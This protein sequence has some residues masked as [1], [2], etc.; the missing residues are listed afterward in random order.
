MDKIHI[1]M[2]V[3]PK[4]VFDKVFVTLSHYDQSLQMTLTSWK[5]HKEATNTP[6]MISFHY[7]PF[8]TFL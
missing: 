4:A 1:I 2:D 3:L 5:P 7:I 8:L 6:S